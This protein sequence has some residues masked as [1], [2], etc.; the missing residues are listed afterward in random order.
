MRRCRGR[1]GQGQ[2]TTRARLIIARQPVISL[3]LLSGPMPRRA[4]AVPRSPEM[5]DVI[6][7]SGDTP[8]LCRSAESEPIGQQT[9]P[10]SK[11]V[12]SD[13]VLSPARLVSDSGHSKDTG[14]SGDTAST[15]SLHDSDIADDPDEIWNDLGLVA[16]DTPVQPRRRRRLNT[17]ST[18]ASSPHVTWPRS[19]STRK[20]TRTKTL[21]AQ[22]VLYNEN[23]KT[24]WW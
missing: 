21:A 5:C 24:P 15:A 16:L 7:P 4:T 2:L 19:A 8:A 9:D 17:P 6:T 14:S 12:N 3:Q 23:T 10:V 22:S 13:Q 20:V 11:C 1:G 18:G